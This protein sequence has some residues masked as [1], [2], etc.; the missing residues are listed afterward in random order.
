MPIAS[1]FPE[2]EELASSV[3]FLFASRFPLFALQLGFQQLVFL[4]NVHCHQHGQAGAI[5][6]V[7]G[8]LGNSRHLRIDVSSELENLVVVGI[9]DLE[10]G[11]K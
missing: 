2:S 11:R 9:V 8:L 1:P 4:G 5:D 10:V 6:L 3:V 7:W